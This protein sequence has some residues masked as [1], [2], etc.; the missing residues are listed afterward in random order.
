MNI[1]KV[2][3]QW[4]GMVGEPK[5]FPFGISMGE[6]DRNGAFPEET[7]ELLFVRGTTSFCN[8]KITILPIGES[9]MWNV[10]IW[11][12]EPCWRGTISFSAMFH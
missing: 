9:T 8:N 6:W 2:T 11:W 3:K 1:H 12:N 4:E 10:Q 7:C 5:G